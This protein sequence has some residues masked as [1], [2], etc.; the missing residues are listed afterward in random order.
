MYI[1]R[2]ITALCVVFTA[3]AF[4][5][6]AVELLAPA[7]NAKVMLL[8]SDWLQQISERSQ[9]PRVSLEKIDK[10]DRMDLPQPVTFMWKKKSDGM[11]K[12]SCDKNF[13]TDVKTI[14]FAACD[15]LQVYNLKVGKTYY[16]QVITDKKVSEVRKFTA[17]GTT[18]RYIAVPDGIPV[19][20]RDAGGK[21][22]AGGKRTRQNMI[23]RGSEMHG[24]YAISN[25]AKN[26]M[27]NELK[28]RTDLD[29]RY[30]QITARFQESALGKSVQ[31]ICMPINAYQ[32]FTAEQNNYF[33]DTIKIF[34][35][36]KNYPVYVHCTAGV[37]RTGEVIFL[38][39]MLLNVDEERAFQDYEASSLSYYPRPRS[40]G[41]FQRWLK[42]IAQMS[43][44]GTPRNIQVENYL[45]KIGVT[46]EDISNI[47]KIML[48][49]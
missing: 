8:R 28:I 10:K 32:S 42:T 6:A 5:A 38:L 24:D 45:K 20:M 29:L 3:T 44:A 13:K 47:R 12:I 15:S 40:I 37:D 41:Y 27:L 18:P 25:A 33:R 31:W 14:P 4:T 34:A 2:K 22:A 9:R 16:W 7:D 11:L 1:A 26:F 21:A 35:D 49:Q 39:D 36:H 43:P 48:E 19:N 17:D 23:F 30:P 46:S